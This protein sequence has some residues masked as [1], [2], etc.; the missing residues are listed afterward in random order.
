MEQPLANVAQPASQPTNTPSS[1]SHTCPPGGCENCVKGGM[2]FKKEWLSLAVLVLIGMVTVLGVLLVKEKR[3]RLMGGDD[4]E[5]QV[6]PA[7]ASNPQPKITEAVPAPKAL[8]E[9]I[10]LPKPKLQSSISVESALASRRTRRAFEAKPVTLA[11]LSQVL[12]SAQGVTNDKGNRTAPS[13]HSVYPYTVYVVVRN[14]AGLPAGLYQYVPESHSLGSLSL[15]NAGELLNAA[16]VQEGAQKAPAVMVLS[17]AYGKMVKSSP[18]DPKTPT[19]LEAGHIGQNVY[20]QLEAL[21]MGGVVMAGFD[22]TKVGQALKLD[23]LETVVYLIPF[24][25]PAAVTASPAVSPAVKAE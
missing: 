9:I 19:I 6:Q 25:H 11:E 8:A 14:V 17:A 18:N 3:E 4:Q 7:T 15:A 12:W 5:R 22:A 21:K 24:G 13:A 20:L 23:Q 1:N 16:G 2:P 10:A